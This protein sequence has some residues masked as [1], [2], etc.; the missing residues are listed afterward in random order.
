[1]KGDFP[2]LPVNFHLFYQLP[3]QFASYIQLNDVPDVISD[4]F[5]LCPAQDMGHVH[6]PGGRKPE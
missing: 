5:T 1:M 3:H 4:S 2:S 6:L